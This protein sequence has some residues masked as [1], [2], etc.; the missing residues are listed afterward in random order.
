M[1]QRWVNVKLSFILSNPNNPR[2][3]GFKLN[4]V[5]MQDF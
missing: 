1:R 2:L 4:A 3:F 5:L